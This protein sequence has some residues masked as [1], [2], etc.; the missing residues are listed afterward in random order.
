MKIGLDGMA[1]GLVGFAWLGAIDSLEDHSRTANEKNY[2]VNIDFVSF[3]GSLKI[4]ETIDHDRPRST[5][6]IV[7]IGNR[8]NDNFESK[9][10]SMIICSIALIDLLNGF[11]VYEMAN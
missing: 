10:H 1:P 6:E 9:I 5:V 11:S 4:N 7:T 3:I 2:R 8:M